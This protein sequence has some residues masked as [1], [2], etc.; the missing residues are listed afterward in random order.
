MAL[1]PETVGSSGEGIDV[2]VEAGAGE[3]GRLSRM[4]HIREAGACDRRSVERRRRREGA[5][6]TAEE[7]RGFASGQVLI[8]FLSPLDRPRR[9]RTARAAR[10]AWRSR[11]SRCR[12]SRA[13]SRWTRCRRRRRWRATRRRCSG[14]P[15]AA[16]LPDAD[17]CGGDDPAREGAGARRGRR[18]AAG[19]RDRAPARR[20]RARG[21][22]SALRCASRSSRWARPSS[23]SASR[24]RRPRAA[25][26]A[27]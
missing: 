4:L 11:S 19:D 10:R 14:R 20:G 9:R 23:I 16:V 17:D 6:P 3:R 7:A 1:I 18:G 12:G 26:R 8:A 2:V 25:T 27:S 24:A 5:A 21:S 13:R 15:P 22:T